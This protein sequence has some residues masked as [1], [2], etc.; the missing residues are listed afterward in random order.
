MDSFLS[1]ISSH[2]RWPMGDENICLFRDLAP[3]FPKRLTSWEIKA[4]AMELGL[5]R[6][7]IDV[8]ALNLYPFIL[9]VSAISETRLNLVGF[10]LTVT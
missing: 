1:Q 9:Q 3:H 2:V 5:P 10:F 7:S 6:W 4:P 8:V